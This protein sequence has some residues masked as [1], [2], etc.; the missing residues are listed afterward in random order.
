M[1]EDPST[2]TLYRNICMLV[3][4]LGG[5]RITLLG[6][7]RYKAEPVWQPIFL[8]GL[9]MT[10]AYVTIVSTSG[11]GDSFQDLTHRGDA[12]VA[13]FVYLLKAGL[14]VVLFGAIAVSKKL[15]T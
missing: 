13:D 15:L 8:G 14:L 5:V 10:A 3:A 11:F 2:A 7:K 6:L 12:V 1:L 4:A 9:M